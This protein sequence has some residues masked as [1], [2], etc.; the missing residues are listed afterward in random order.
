MLQDTGERL[1]LNDN[2]NLKTK[3]EHIHR[4]TAVSRKLKDK[5]VLDAACGTG[6]GTEIISRY[7][8][9]AVGIDLSLEAV[10]YAAGKYKR[11]NLKYLKMSVAD[12]DFPDNSFDAVVSFETIEHISQEQQKAFLGE[13]SRV[14]K[15][16]GVFFVSTPNDEL[17]RKLT[18]GAYTNP[19]HVCEFCEEDFET[20]LKQYFKYVNVYYQSVA[21]ASIMVRKGNDQGCGEL[22]SNGSEAETERFYI[23][24]C[25]N[26]DIPVNLSLDSTYKPA[27]RDYYDEQNFL[28]NAYVHVDTGDGFDGKEFA[29]AKCYS[30]DG[31]TFDYHF[32]LSQFQNIKALRFDPAEHAGIYKIVSIHSNLPEIWIHPLNADSTLDGVDTFTTMDPIYLITADNISQIQS[33]DISGEVL[34]EFSDYIAWNNLESK[35][36]DVEEQVGKEEIR[37]KE[38]E[39]NEIKNA[40][41]IQKEY[42][43]QNEVLHNATGKNVQQVET[44]CGEIAREIQNVQEIV[45]KQVLRSEELNQQLFQQLLKEVANLNFIMAKQLRDT[46]DIIYMSKNT[47]RTT[48]DMLY[49][50]QHTGWYHRAIRRIEKPGIMFRITR[51]VRQRGVLG[52]A[53]VFVKKSAKRLYRLSKKHKVLKSLLNGIRKLADQI[54]P[55]LGA[56]LH[57]LIAESKMELNQDSLARGKAL[58]GNAAAWIGEKPMPFDEKPLVS[59]IVPNFNHSAYLMDRLESVYNQTYPNFEVILLDDCSTDDSRAILMEYAEKYPDKTVVD[60]NEINGGKVFKQWNKGIAHAKGKLIWIA[61]SDD[62]CELDFLEKMVPQFEYESVMLAFCR[63]LFMQNG[64]QVWS[65]EEYL[66]D[67][68]T[69]DFSKPFVASAHIAVQNGFAL[70]NM[71]PNV[72]SAVFRNIGQIPQTITEIWEN[73]KLCGDWLFYL[74]MIRGGC[75][76]YTNETTNYYRVH[77]NSTSLKIQKSPAY[78]YEQ[79]QISQFVAMN[80]NVDMGVFQKVLEGLERH[81]I[82]LNEVDD[83]SVVHDNYQLERIT[84]AASERK[85]NILMCCFSLQMGGGETYPIYLANEMRKQGACVTL[86]NFDMDGYSQQVRE[87]IDPSVPVIHLK[88]PDY[89]GSILERTG[90]NIVHSHHASV[91][92]M[93]SEWLKEWGLPCKQVVSLHGMYETMDK[94]SCERIF[95]DLAETCGQF[96]Y[97]ADKNLTRIRELGFLDHLP[98]VKIGNALPVMKIN[99][100]SRDS[101]NIAKEDFVLCLVSR[102]IKEKGWQEAIQ[103][104]LLANKTSER[105]IHLVLI[106]DGLMKEKMETVQSPYIHVLGQRPNIRDYF[107]MA[108]MGFLPSKFRGESFPLVVIDSLM[109]GRPVLASD[110]GEIRNQLMD[111]R[112]ELAGE[113]F[114]LQDWKIDVT[115]LANRIIRIAQNETYYRV[116]TDRVPAA[117][118]KYD[119][120]KITKQYQAI[121]QKL[122]NEFGAVKK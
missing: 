55:K 117:R 25:S 58:S 64:S 74:Y 71:I 89:L 61:E 7:A 43:V 110:I 26:S 10:Q 34:H 29:C 84:A 83:L 107:S 92:Q 103:A 17:E 111:D 75:L 94:E 15:D 42:A 30:R 52:S 22:Y 49:V 79:E 85:P 14:L 13:V 113:L 60:F 114:S 65:L 38:S 118:T 28:R 41:I 51:S 96:V 70:K 77:T 16:T 68:S 36:R 72:S 116:L 46:E 5:D 2:W 69:F 8:A 21:S 121:Y 37:I 66:A 90:A 102:A 9:H 101:L 18:F 40:L 86:L 105:K 39:L 19:Y 120:S 63:S 95:C 119:I 4:Y 73:F 3:M 115:D 109:A 80:Y 20:L 62:W 78:Y 108:D 31:K 11:D 59:V 99:P 98:L 1:I 35:L 54:T 76:S 88:S 48:T 104:V 81:Y 50:M 112:G 91:D 122:Y 106:G 53:K 12:L 57:R 45:Q 97:T 93:V 100:I 82:A 6:Y 56:K 27:L 32:D 44:L 24:V 23:A 47:Q 33:V 87:L 67:I